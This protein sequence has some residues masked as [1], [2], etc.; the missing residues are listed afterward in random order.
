[1]V[2]ARMRVFPPAYAQ[3]VGFAAAVLA[4]EPIAPPN[5]DL[6]GT[7]LDK[8]LTVQPHREACKTHM[9]RESHPTVNSIQSHD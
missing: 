3:E 6:D 1:M 4:D 5:G 7:V 9:N 2:E 8:L